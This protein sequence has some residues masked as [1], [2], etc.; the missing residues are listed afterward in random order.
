MKNGFT[1]FILLI[2]FSGLLYLSENHSKFVQVNDLNTSVDYK[3]GILKSEYN[4]VDRIA[5]YNIDVEFNPAS[6]SILVNQEI[7]WI[8]RTKFSTSEIQFHFYANA[9]KSNNTLFAKA[10]SL[11]PEAQ[12]QI[13]IKSFQVNGESSQLVYFQPEIANPHDSTVAKVLLNKTIEPGDSVRINFEYTMK[14]P[15]SIKRM[16]YAT[17]R[18][19]FFVSQW[20]PKVGVFENGKWVCS[21]YHPY[22]NFYSDFGDYSVKIKVPKNY[23]VAATGV[24]KGNITDEKTISYNF[25]QSGVHDFVWLATDEI[26]HRNNIYTRK[27][28]STI[29]IQ[30]YV[31]PERERYFDRYFTAVKNCLEY[32]ENNIG[33]YPYQNVSLV[34]VPRTSA[35]GGMEYPTLFT[36]GSELFA[37]KDAGQPEYLVTHEFSHQFFY[38]LIANNEVYEAWLDE[39]FTSYISTKIMYHYQPEIFETFKFATYI[40]V[41]GLDF[42]SYNEIPLIYTLADVKVPEGARSIASYYKN[43]TIGSIADT[44]YKLPTRLSYVVN[45]YNKP[46][47]VLHTLERYLGHDKMMNILKEYYNEYKYKHPKGADFINI[48]K[49]NCNEDMSWF[50]DEFYRAP[51][52]F[53]YQVT[54]IKKT[55]SNEYEILVERLGDGIFKNDVALY[56]DK[57]TL[58]QKWDGTERWKI[59][60]FKTNNEVIAAEIDPYRKNLLDINFA[61][62]S[63]T[64]SHRVWAS[65]SLSIRFFFWVQN[66][67]MILGSIG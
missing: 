25:V 55:S 18:N 48:V 12:T 24:E 40:P 16:G 45:S 62:N 37:P 56:T 51:K 67:L 10:Y 46:A 28:G 63:L 59:L 6:K 61:N 35:S 7:I 50:F 54:S 34:D 53:D 23:I 15:R 39:G 19:F 41:F 36:V 3:D 17:G 21:Q 11:S 20:F 64:V 13:D 29:T 4:K 66:A 33:I 1:V 30:A 57:D 47:L 32:F 52:T 60:K 14:I 8:N 58:Y 49:R 27:D 31:Q 43:L 38:G 9:Y 22:L 44:S 65:L 26:L 2:F 42:L 5:N